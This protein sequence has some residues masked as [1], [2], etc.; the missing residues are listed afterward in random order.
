MLSTAFLFHFT[1]ASLLFFSFEK[2]SW[3]KLFSLFSCRSESKNPQE[4][5][6]S[7]EFISILCLTLLQQYKEKLGRRANSF[8]K[9]KGKLLNIFSM[10]LDS[11]SFLN[12]F[13]QH[14]I[15]YVVKL[16]CSEKRLNLK[17]YY[18]FNFDPH[19]Y[20]FV[21]CPSTKKFKDNHFEY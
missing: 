15:V 17:R 6:N 14:D 18:I 4:N 13:K 8:L 19:F 10:Y 16:I 21:N 9:I 3:G 12:E 7:K 2:S 1:I 5:G 20:R 11:N